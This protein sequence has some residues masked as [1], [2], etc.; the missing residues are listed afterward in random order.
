MG[1]VFVRQFPAPDIDKK[2]VMRYSGAISF[3]PETEKLYHECI[4]ECLTKTVYRVCYSETD[5]TI[6]DNQITLGG[7][8][9]YSADLAKRL[10]GCDNVIVFAAT[11]GLEYD[12]LITSYGRLDAAKALMFQAI[13][14]E[15]VE[16]LC[17]AFCREM[18]EEKTNKGEDVTTRFSPGYGDLPLD[19]QK[20]VF[21]MLGCEKRI[22]VYLNKSLL[23]TP[24]K[25]VTAVVG[26]R[27]HGKQ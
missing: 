27:K 15:R 10:T 11:V 12:R 5:I 26:I 17:N 3:T 24:S 9:I 25:S 7:T 18:Q 19:T 22:G 1:E 23:M 14:T 2:A 16:S 20:V 21:E 13:G 8:K 6:I 4:K